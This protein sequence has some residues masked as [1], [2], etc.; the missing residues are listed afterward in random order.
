MFHEAVIIAL[1]VFAMGAA[2]SLMVA[3]MIKGIFVCIK[4]RETI[5]FK[6]TKEKW[7]GAT[8]ASKS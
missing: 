4:L 1:L 8:A 6:S 5:K 7:Q 3:A 2:I